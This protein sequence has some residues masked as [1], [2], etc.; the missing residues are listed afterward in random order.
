MRFVV[1]HIWSMIAMVLVS[2]FSGSILSS[3]LL[4]PIKTIE[5][6]DQLKQSNLSLITGNWSY[7]WYSTTNNQTEPKLQY[8]QNKI[9]ISFNDWEVSLN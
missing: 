8:L 7:L 2:C 1:I 6:F 5:N 3:I 9:H 4:Q